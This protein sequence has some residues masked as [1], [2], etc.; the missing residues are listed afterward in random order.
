M[1][2]RVQFSDMRYEP[3]YVHSFGT[4]KKLSMPTVDMALWF[5]GIFDKEKICSLVVMPCI[6]D[7]YVGTGIP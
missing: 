6:I 1:S 5:I 2:D 4:T 3:W 7:T